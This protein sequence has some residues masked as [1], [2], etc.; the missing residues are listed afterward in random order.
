MQPQH[1]RVIIIGAGAAG[2]GMAVTMKTFQFDEICVLESG[3]IGQSFKNW[4]KSTRTITPSFT[5]NGF[6]M[7]D[8][9]AISTDTSPA[10]TFNE[11]HLSGERY[12]EYLTVVA[13]HYDIPI[14]TQTYVEDV[15]WVDGRYELSTSR[16]QFSADYLFIATGDFAFPNQPFEHGLHYSEVEDFRE[17]PGEAFTIIGGNESA[18][19]A[20]IHLAQRGAQVSIYT[21]STGFDAE[22]ADPSIRLSPYTYQRLR[23]VLEQGKEI[24]INVN[25]RAESIVYR[26]QQYEI[27]FE[28]GAVVYSQTEPIIATGFDVTQ[29]PLV[30]QLFTVQEGEVRLTDLDESTR[31]PNVFLIGA[32]VRHAEAILCYIYKFRARFAV[33]TRAVM[34]REQLTVDTA[35]IERYR[36]NQMYLDD[37]RCCEVDCSC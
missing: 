10:F 15:Q 23:D 4:P 18:F 24:E 12:A 3:T 19:D 27:H 32:T 5:S 17:L 20:A 30:Q 14:Q 6:G 16:G 34:E 33:L 26:H 37:Y 29:N 1:H 22:V 11:E 31:Y 8:M 35:C 28:H 7:P 25:Y 36:D 2:I 21:S 9:N 13:E